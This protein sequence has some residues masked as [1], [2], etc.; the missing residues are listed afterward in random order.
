MKRRELIKSSLLGLGASA[1]A[2]SGCNKENNIYDKSD[3]ELNIIPKQTAQYEFSCPLPFNYKT[4]DEIVE[5]NKT[6]KKSKVTTFY[7]NAPNQDFNNWVSISRAKNDKFKTYEEFGEFA[8]YAI[9]KGFN[10]SYLMNSPKPY[11][12]KDFRTFGKEFYDLLEYLY[13]IQIRDIKISNP[14]VALYI[15]SKFPNMFNLH[16]STAF[17]YNS[18]S[19]YI[20]L[21]KLY[22]NFTLIDVSNNENQNFKLLKSLRDKFPNI[23]LELMVNEGCIKFCPVRIACV[24]EGGFAII[25]CGPL[26]MEKSAISHFT[27]TGAIYPWNL[28][29]YSALGINNFKF[30]SSTGKE[31]TRSNYHDITTLKKYLTCVEEGIENYSSNFFFEIFEKLKDSPYIQQD[32]TKEIKLSELKD[33]L[34]DI[35][36]FIKHGHECAIKCNHECNYCYE[37]SKKIDNALIYS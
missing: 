5:L 12:H 14:Q 36:Y 16:C 32:K 27:K 18:L 25:D 30:I 8:K 28:E 15:N 3:N 19:Q 24:T 31:N 10:I 33:M 4:I 17:E 29:Y 9:D 7:N 6:L 22:P 11:S 34:P 26:Q 20:Y 23:K 21:F 35:R 13:K 37:C 1:L 2:L